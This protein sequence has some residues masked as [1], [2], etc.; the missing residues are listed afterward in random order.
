[1]ATDGS[2]N[3]DGS[4]NSAG[5]RTG[6]N[7]SSITDCGSANASSINDNTWSK[8]STS[9]SVASGV[10]VATSGVGTASNNSLKTD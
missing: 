2:N 3:A 8:G 1:M 7:G 4:N 5:S 9:P 6:A 10:L